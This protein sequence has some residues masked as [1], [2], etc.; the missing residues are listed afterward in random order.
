MKTILIVSIAAL[1]LCGCHHKPDVSSEIQRLKDRVEV[2]EQNYNKATNGIESNKR[3]FLDLAEV[4]EDQTNL[5]HVFELEFDVLNTEVPQLYGR[6]DNTMYLIT[7][8]PVARAQSVFQAA[9]AQPRPV[10]PQ[11]RGGVPMAVYNQIVADAQSQFP[12]DYDEQEYI[13]KQ[14]VSAYQRLHP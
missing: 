9:P 1:L 11:L 8:R 7:N 2:L 14:Q 6:L 10:A 12:T 3:L 5:F 4:V 13:I